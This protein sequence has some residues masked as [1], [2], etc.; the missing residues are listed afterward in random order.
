MNDRT[1][2][3]QAIVQARVDSSSKVALENVVPLRTPFSAHIDVC[4]V[5]NFKCSFCF[6]ADSEGMKAVNLKRSMM[7]VELFKKIVDDLKRFPDP[8]RKVKIGNHGE[9]TLHPRLGEMIA[10]LRDAQVT[11]IIELFTNGSMLNPTMN[12]E[13]IDAGLQRINISLEGMD[14][15][16]YERVA[17]VKMDM[18]TLVESIAHLYEIRGDCR[19]YVKIANRVGV[20]DKQDTTILTLSEE[21]HDRFFATFGNICDEI[22]VENVVPQ[23]ARIQTDKQNDLG[24][25]GMYGQKISRYKQI[26][27]FIFMYLHFNWDGT[28][29]PCTLDWAKKVLIG[30]A[31][32]ESVW[33]IWNGRS[34]RLLQRAQLEGL[35]HRVDFCNDCSA[36]MV[37]CNEDLDEQAA[38]ILGRLANGQDNGQD[39]EETTNPWVGA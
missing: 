27:P 13:L 29:S 2:N 33:D 9:P 30:N 5:C 26:C 39:N 16:T 31:G 15:E 37:C 21:D 24:N 8:F 1:G 18:S 25:I 10:Y 12:R 22:Y 38:A 32:Q 4:S 36:P 20:L 14:S 34:L 3:I 19:I 7:P 6:Q 17:G 23:W 11:D 35:R 28:T